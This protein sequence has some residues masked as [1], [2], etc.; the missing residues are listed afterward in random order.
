MTEN[1][2][3]VATSNAV[4]LDQNPAAVSLASLAPTGRRSMGAHLL[5]AGVSSGV[6]GPDLFRGA[7]RALQGILKEQG[8]AMG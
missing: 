7:I 8:L 1:A 3:T 5:I 2:L 4:S 6:S